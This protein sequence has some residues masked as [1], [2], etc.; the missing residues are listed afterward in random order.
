MLALALIPGLV[1]LFVVWK[2]DTVEKESPV[3]LA[4]LFAA[5]VAVMLADILIRTLGLK[6]LEGTYNGTSILLYIF[7]DAFIFTALIEEGG[8]FIALKLLTWKNKEFNYTFDAIVYSVAVSVGFIITENIVLIIRYGS[9]LDPVKILLP[10]FAQLII[11][12]FMG[13]FYGTAKVAESNGDLKSRKMHEIE[14]VLIPVVIHG[15]FE[16]CENS[17]SV[18]LYVVFVLYTLCLTVLAIFVFTNARKGDTRIVWGTTDMQEGDGFEINVTSLLH[19]E[20]DTEGK[21]AADESKM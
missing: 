6:L 15:L 4:K 12:V 5:G 11:S 9:A 20:K 21:E 14:A 16:M 2:L 10:L 13:F 19:G 18:V 8:R 7:L 1:L 3:L 17:E